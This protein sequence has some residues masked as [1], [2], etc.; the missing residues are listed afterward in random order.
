MV[1]CTCIALSASS[2]FALSSSISKFLN[3]LSLSLVMKPLASLCIVTVDLSINFSTSARSYSMLCTLCDII[4]WFCASSRSVL[5][6][7]S[8]SCRRSSFCCSTELAIFC[9]LGS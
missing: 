1:I 2:S 8:F 7:C 9:I 3:F 6:F 4:S 5:S